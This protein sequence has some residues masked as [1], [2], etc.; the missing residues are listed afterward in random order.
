[1]TLRIMVS[2]H[3]AELQSNVVSMVCSSLMVVKTKLKGVALWHEETCN[4]LLLSNSFK[5]V[6][7]AM[8]EWHTFHDYIAQKS[9]IFVKFVK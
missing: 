4:W 5:H 1:M 2:M 7:V 9:K 8:Q 6:Y 3:N